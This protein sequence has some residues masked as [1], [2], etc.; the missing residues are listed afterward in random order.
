MAMTAEIQMIP[1]VTKDK[2]GK[3]KQ[4]V[5]RCLIY[6]IMIELAVH[7]GIVITSA[8]YLDS[9]TAIVF[10]VIILSG[11]NSMLSYITFHKS[12]L[13][14]KLVKY[15][16]LD[17]AYQMSKENCKAQLSKANDIRR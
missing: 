14:H 7:I 4:E 2:V 6:W 11:I 1:E 15:I 12:H 9:K 13:L 8:A 16:N 17:T 3:A 10:M 5:L